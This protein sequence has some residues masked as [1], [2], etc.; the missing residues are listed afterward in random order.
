VTDRSKSRPAS[1]SQAGLHST[2]TFRPRPYRRAWWLPGAH[3][4]TIGAW[5]LRRRGGVRLHRE[6]LQT[7]DGDF[8]DL[9]FSLPSGARSHLDTTPG[10]PIVLILH[11]LEGGSQAL[12]ALQA[13]RTLAPLGLQAVTM[14]FRSCS[15]EP[16]LTARFYHAG[17][18]GDL[19]LVLNWL[20]ERFSDT[21]VGVLGYSL[22]G[23]VLL[24]FLGEQEERARERVHAAVAVSVPFDLMAGAHKLERGMGRLY[25][26]HFLRSLQRK[27][28]SKQAL[29]GDR[30]D[31]AR[32]KRARTLREF[33]DAATAPLHGFRDV[34]HYYHSSSSAAFLPR[35]RVPTLLLHSVDDPFLPEDAVP[36]SEV[37][38][39]P[40]LTADFTR[41]GGHMGFV[42][43]PHPWAVEY[44][45]ES[46]AA[47]FLAMHLR[48]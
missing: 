5:L 6:R 35:I 46:E 10:T 33:D 47:R 17:E 26:A 20:K 1:T 22:G 38:R 30:C 16:N 34:E 23:N 27:F 43:G 32:I 45:A 48:S 21:P 13:M 41:H 7:P 40:C 31:G 14:N 4:Q 3:L 28:I 12:P 44:W 9:D 11:G 2:P 29:I 24:K 19:A 42:A 18:T 15:G 36:H 39:N 25:T 37:E 8:V